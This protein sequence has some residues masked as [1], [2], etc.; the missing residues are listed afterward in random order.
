MGKRIKEGAMGIK[1]KLLELI[2]KADRTSA[3]QL[4]DSWASEHSYE[5]LMADILEPVLAEIGRRWAEEGVSLAQGYITAKI[6]EDALNKVVTERSGKNEITERKGPVIMGN[7]EDD[8]HSLGRKMVVTFLEADG[9]D[10][11][12]LGNDVLASEFVDTAL[13]IGAKVIGVSAMMYTTAK[14]IRKVRDE[15]DNRNLTGKIQLAAGGA[16]FVLRP[17]LIADV[18]GDGTARNAI[19]APELFSRLMKNAIEEG[20]K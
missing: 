9:W 11:H 10:V 16:V 20:E 8:S 17:E 18:G 14:N 4:L 7:I 15:I 1:E 13:Q 2:A 6:T 5:Q 19:G 3:S 12:D